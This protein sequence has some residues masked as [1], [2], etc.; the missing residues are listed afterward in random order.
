MMDPRRA[1]PSVGA[2]LESEAVRALLAHAPRPVVAEAVR[3]ALAD[4]RQAPHETPPSEGEWA[5]RIA[6]HLGASTRP[7]LRALINATGVVL[8]T[9]L[10]RAVLAERALAAVHQVA[11]SYSNLEFDL[12]RGER[13][14]RATHCARLLIELTGAEDALVVNNGAAALLLA[15]TVLAHGREAIVSRGELI[16]IG[17][18]FRVPDIM[19]ASGARLREVGT[20]NRTHLDDYRRA[21]SPTTGTLVKVH[22][23]NFALEGY[24]AEVEPGMLAALGR[25]VGV[26]LVH[27]LG[28]GLLVSLD[29]HGLRGEPVAADAVRD[30]ATIVTMSGDKLLGG[31]Q[32]GIVLGQRETVAR[33]KAHPLARALRVD[34]MTLAGLE[35]TLAL[36]RDD[37]A[38]AEIP[39]LAMLTAPVER[40][41]ERAEALAE[42]L[43]ASG[44]AATAIESEA[45]TGGGAF[46]TARIPSAAVALQGDAEA[47]AAALRAGSPP[48]VGRIR[49]GAL[50]L[51]VRTV[52]P[53]DDER[54]YQA[55]R[56]AVP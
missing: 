47:L 9:N 33:L 25:E 36:Y 18:S 55:V 30:G 48:V 7:S 23:S 51:D 8:H 53:P 13:G 15:L 10:G 1:L 16:E 12:D 22:R 46:P 39:T 52:A 28:S 41:R 19:A 3:A 4:A 54:L 21:L 42:R 20:T 43:T 50:L 11:A 45:Q 32:A 26:P 17:G 49:N 6:A 2:L 37:R 35:A 34:K 31:P 24:V 14:S 44:I 40:L 56:A 38:R 5:G 29:E 27:D